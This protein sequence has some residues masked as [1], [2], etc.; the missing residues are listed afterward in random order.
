MDSNP[1]KNNN[2]QIL[3]P[4]DIKDNCE[5]EGDESN[6][7]IFKGKKRFSNNLKIKKKISN[8]NKFVKNPLITKFNENSKFIFDNDMVDEYICKVKD[9]NSLKLKNNE[10]QSIQYLIDKL[11]LDKT[12]FK[13]N[14]I[15]YIK[16]ETADDIN[17]YFIKTKN[18]NNPLKSFLINELN[19][20]KDHNNITVRKLSSKYEKISGKRISKSTIHNCLKKELGYKYMKTT[21]KTNKILSKDN[22]LLSFAF[23]KIIARSISFKFNLV[24]IDETSIQ[25]NNNNYF[26]WRKAQQNIYGELGQKKKLNLLMAIDNDSVVYYE[27]KEES[28]NEEIFYNFMKNLIFHLK[29]KKI[30]P[31]ILILDNFSCHKTRKLIELYSNNK[32]NILF[33]TPYLSSFNSIELSFRNMKRYLY[34]KCFDTIET[35]KKEAEKY[36]LQEEFLNGIKSNFKETLLRYL[37]F[38]S[39]HSHLNLNNLKE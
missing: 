19:S 2:S 26:C 5:L 17:N 21:I 8:H 39:Y 10:I 12:L 24:Y 3:K 31:S 37:Q 20:E 23:I 27:F 9:I 35:M 15:I 30:F 11:D 32:I 29:K 33:N 13:S 6:H 16:K 28:T 22:I 14:E 36:L 34:T 1:D 25:N 4:S 38:N 7:K 18:N